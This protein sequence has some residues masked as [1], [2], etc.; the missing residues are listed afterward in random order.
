MSIMQLSADTKPGDVMVFNRDV[1]I[2][3]SPIMLN[4]AQLLEVGAHRRP[5]DSATSKLPQHLPMHGKTQIPSEGWRS[6]KL[7]L[8]QISYTCRI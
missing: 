4:S 8:L 7:V 1:K 3:F 5:R 6:R 2:T